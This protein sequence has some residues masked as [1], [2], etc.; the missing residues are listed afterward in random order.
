MPTVC[1]QI[2]LCRRGEASTTKGRGWSERRLGRHLYSCCSAGLSVT[3][4]QRYITSLCLLAFFSH[5]SFF[6]TCFFLS[7]F[8]SFFFFI[9]SRLFENT[10]I[11][12]EWTLLQWSYPQS[13]LLLW[14]FL[15]S[16]LLCLWSSRSGCDAS[17]IN[18]LLF[19]VHF[20]LKGKFND[21]LTT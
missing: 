17:T 16:D 20:A 12:E 9:S 4:S 5:L 10:Q 7:F 8:F 14:L 18:C 3:S 13:K 15:A 2:N 21:N 11:I 6:P 19:C 1:I